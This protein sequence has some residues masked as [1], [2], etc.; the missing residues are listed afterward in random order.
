VYHLLCQAVPI[1]PRPFGYKGSHS[2]HRVR[3]STDGGRVFPLGPCYLHPVQ[4]FQLI[5]LCRASRLSVRTITTLTC[6]PPTF[7]LA[8]IVLLVD[9]RAVITS[10]HFS[11]MS[12]SGSISRKRVGSVSQRGN[13]ALPPLDIQSIQMPSNP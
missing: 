1:S 7:A 4:N 11:T 6:L 12:M 10:P 8:V 3:S 9:T 2:A 5:F 13:E